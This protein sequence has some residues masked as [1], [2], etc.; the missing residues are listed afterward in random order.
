MIKVISDKKKICIVILSRANY[1]SIKTVLE[2]ITKSSK[3]TLQ[4]VLGGS[5]VLEKYGT[6]DEILKKDGFKA[7]RKLSFMLDGENPETMTKSTGL[8]IVEISTALKSLK[9]DF[10]LTVGDRYETMAT[11]ICATYMNIPLIHTMGGE[12]SGTIDE[13]IRHATTKFA[14]IHFPAT[15]KA[16]NKIIKLGENKKNV[17][18]V[19][20]PRIDLVK[21]TLTKKR[22]DLNKVLTGLGVGR[23]FNLNKDF[24]IIMQYS[25]TTEYEDS[26]KQIL[27]TLKAVTNFNIPTLVFWPNSDAGSNLISKGIRTWRE[28]NFEKKFWFLK[29]LPTET[30]YELLKKAKCM[31]GNSSS[32]I[33]ECSYLGIPFVNVGTRQKNREKGQNTINA[34]NNPKDI[35]KAIKK[36][37][38]LKPKKSKIYGEGNAAKKI[39]KVLE[40]IRHINLQK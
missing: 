35:S 11:T 32:G 6:L 36:A 21:K 26:K 3:L 39:V 38:K 7:N 24:L 23:E 9:P 13:S 33:R 19:G 27:N 30:F 31:V 20:C 12:S 14:H 1:G 2:E 40:K 25:V 15:K 37:L 8:A 17:F 18:F 10:V 28:K 5:A 4:I 16:K 29:N 22:S 34:S